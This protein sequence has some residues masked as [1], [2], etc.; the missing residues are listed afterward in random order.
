MARW[1]LLVWLALCPAVFVVLGFASPAAAHFKLLK[2]VPAD[3]T[4]VDGAVAEIRLTFSAPGTPTAAGFK[5]SREG[6]AVPVTTH[7]PDGGRTWLVHP[8]AALTGGEFTL[9]WSVAAPD[10]HPLTGDVTFTVVPAARHRARR[11]RLGPPPARD[12]PVTVDRAFRRRP[13]RP[14]PALT[15]WVTP[16]T[17]TRVRCGSSA[18]RGGGCPTERSCSAW[19]VWS[20]R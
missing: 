2:V 9:R 15:R 17:P 13:H 7:T 12:T 19:A 6:A 14:T 20:S 8:S 3:G 18:R 10:A 11:P 5:L 16:P 4:R 1:V